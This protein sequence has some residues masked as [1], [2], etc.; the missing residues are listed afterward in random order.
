MSASHPRFDPQAGL[1]QKAS[2]RAGDEA[3]QGRQVVM[4]EGFSLR[5]LDCFA[6]LAMTL[7]FLEFSN[8]FLAAAC[9]FFILDFPPTNQPLLS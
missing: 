4:L 5:R 1:S 7:N 6:S 8:Q 3:T 2:L 9:Q